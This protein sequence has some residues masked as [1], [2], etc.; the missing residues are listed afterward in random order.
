MNTRSTPGHD[1]ATL[2]RSG[3]VV[4]NFS[5]YAHSGTDFDAPFQR[6]RIVGCPGQCLAELRW[7]PKR[8]AD[9]AE[10]ALVVAYRIRLQPA[11]RLLHEIGFT[12]IVIFKE[13]MTM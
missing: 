10:P 6:R 1:V 8:C 4:R 2:N 5:Q 3:D 7:F 12:V 13:Q 9:N 11:I